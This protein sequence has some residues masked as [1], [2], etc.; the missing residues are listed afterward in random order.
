MILGIRNRTENWKTA[1]TFARMYPE[2]V[3]ALANNLLKPYSYVSRSEF[4][5]IKSDEAHLELFWKGVRDY[6]HTKKVGKLELMNEFA[7]LYNH[8]FKDLYNRFKSFCETSDDAP[9]KRALSFLNPQNYVVSNNHG[10]EGLFNNLRNT[11]FD[12]IIESPSHLFIGEAKGEMS[13]G[14]QGHLVLVHQLIRQFVTAT[15][16][17][18]HL[19]QKKAIVPFIVWNRPNAKRRDVQVQFMLDQNWL[20]KENILSWSRVERLAGVHS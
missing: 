11:E 13:F 17:L 1:R 2:N 10:K 8:V 9:A 7:E 15:I 20:K 6:V 3:A 19:N 18:A 12:I 5:I 4:R 16:L 14:A